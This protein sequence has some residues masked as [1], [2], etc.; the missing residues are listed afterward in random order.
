MI[1]HLTPFASELRSF[2]C[3]LYYPHKA[4]AKLG[5]Q[6]SFPPTEAM[7]SQARKWMERLIQR[8]GV[9]C[10]A[11]RVL[12]REGGGS[13]VVMSS[14]AAKDG[15]P[16]PGVGGHIH[17]MSW[18]LPLSPENAALLPTNLLEF[19]GIYG[20]FVVFGSSIPL[21]HTRVLALTD[22]PTSALVLSKHSAIPEAM[23]M[24]HLRLFDDAKCVRLA[25]ITDI[26]RIFGPGRIFSDT[27]SRGY[28]GIVEQLRV[29]CHT[30]H[31][32]L[33]VPPK[34]N[35]LLDDLRALARDLAMRAD[36][37]LT[38]RPLSK[39][40]SQRSR[41]HRHANKG[42]YGPPTEQHAAQ[43]P[44]FLRSTD[45]PRTPR[46]GT[47]TNA[48]VSFVNFAAR[49]TAP[50]SHVRVVRPAPTSPS[51]PMTK[52]IAAPL[53]TSSA[54]PSPPRAAADSAAR[55]AL[56]RDAPSA[57]PK[58]ARSEPT[59]PPSA[60]RLRQPPIG[61]PR[62]L[63]VATV[64]FRTR[65]VAAPGAAHTFHVLPPPTHGRSLPAAPP[66][67]ARLLFLFVLLQG[68]TPKYALCPGDP[69]MLACLMRGVG[70]A[71]RR[72]VRPNTQH[73]DRS[74]WRKWVAFCRMLNTPEVRDCVDAHAGLDTAGVRHERF[75]QAAFFLCAFHTMVPR[76]RAHHTAKPASA[77]SCLGSVRRVH[78][79]MGIAMCPAPS[80]ALVLADKYVHLHGA[81]ILVPQRR[82]PLTNEQTTLLFGI[83]PGTKLGKHTVGR[84]TPLL[85]NFAAFLTALRHSGSRKA[86]L[87]CVS[88]DDYD[89]P[90]SKSS[91]VRRLSS[92]AI[93]PPATPP[94]SFPAA[95]KPTPLPSCSATS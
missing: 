21:M 87:L 15:T 88:P 59:P 54:R 46:F 47:P 56:R 4:F 41:S 55:F 32:W 76:N 24:I 9:A 66:R 52:P 81:E 69:G 40:E 94:S 93:S 29:Q 13:V 61:P 43:F 20:N 82:E 80:V 51:A 90:G 89:T 84:P 39:E 85:V 17:G 91:T 6:Y 78:K 22:S 92:F 11:V 7:Q 18:Y 34:V 16:T 83:A 53:L 63:A 60:R 19:I 58:R 36:G 68:D 28:F 10:V 79:H 71:V 75:L 27:I 77:V 12:P 2:N 5:V 44:S 72:S 37:A 64:S 38:P 23:Q 14:D 95:P 25:V 74:S 70:S 73:K 8:P 50:A 67:A 30:E 49:P 86:D 42:S 62:P 45:T 31:E 57:F 35:Q 33:V 3:H 65:S 1:E 26:A 48:P